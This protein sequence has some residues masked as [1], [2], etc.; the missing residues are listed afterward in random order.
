AGQ[1]QA[2]RR[3]LRVRA[4]AE[5]TGC[6][7]VGRIAEHLGGRR[8]L[9]VHLESEHRLEQLE[10]LVEVHEVG[11]GHGFDSRRATRAR[12]RRPDE[13]EPQPRMRASSCAA[14]ARR[15][16]IA[17]DHLGRGAN[18]RTLSGA[19]A[20]PSACTAA[21]RSELSE[22]GLNETVRSVASASSWP[23]TGEPCTMPPAVTKRE[24]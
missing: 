6:G 15:S 16:R 10:R 24:R 18:S 12:M 17:A 9:D 23:K 11:L 5:A 3:D 19:G 4:G 2:Q 8:Q 7:R 20:P 13:A 1:P 21:P 22:T 14:A